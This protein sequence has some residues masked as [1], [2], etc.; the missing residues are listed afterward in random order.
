VSAPRPEGAAWDLPVRAFHW[1]LAT[2]VVFSYVTGK[3]GGPWLEWHMKSGYGI[4]ALLLFR[5]A[6]G[7]AGS[8]SARFSAFLRGPRAAISHVH[9]LRAGNPP[10]SSTHNPLGGWMVVAML[11]VLALQAATGLFTND[12]SSHEGPLAALVA[13]AT[14]DRM[15]VIHDWNQW[16][17]VGAV[18]LH[19]AAIAYYQWAL[20]RNLTRAM[21]FGSWRFPLLAVVLAVVAAAIVYA[22][23]VVL[24]RSAA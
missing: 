6:W 1:L 8:P 14:V 22:L 2:L 15:S 20:G 11:A 3:I 4:L 21:A 19:L 7:F 13:N 10:Y 24:P 17:I 16:L 18:A 23:V 5:L 12:E 9:A